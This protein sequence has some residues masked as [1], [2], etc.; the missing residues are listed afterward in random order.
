LLSRSNCVCFVSS[1]VFFFL[2]QWKP[3]DSI[4]EIIARSD[5]V[6]KNTCSLLL[7]YL[8]VPALMQIGDLKQYLQS[9][10]ALDDQ[11]F[12]A[13]VLSVHRDGEVLTLDECLTLSDILVSF[14]AGQS[15]LSLYYKVNKLDI[16]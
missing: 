16:L 12:N 14:W 4:R 5:F 2:R 7:P 15:E 3:D 6:M 1:I 8:K 10:L 11:Y 13:L 9:K